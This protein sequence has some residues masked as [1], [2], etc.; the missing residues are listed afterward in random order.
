MTDYAS[1]GKTR[2]DNIV[3]LTHCKSHQS[4]YTAL[5][6][7]ASAAGTVILQSFSPSPIIGGA[8]GWLRQE[9]RELELLDEITKLTYE[10]KLPSHIIG[11]QRNT[12]ICDYREWRG[13][14]YVPRNMHS[15]IQWS[16]YK[17]YPINHTI[18]DSPWQIIDKKDTDNKDAPAMIA[19]NTQAAEGS[20][21][22][23]NNKKR[24]LDETSDKNVGTVKKLKLSVQ[25]TPVMLQS[26]IGPRWDSKNYSCAYDAVFSILCYI[27]S[28]NPHKWNK[29]F[30]GL[31]PEMALL[32]NGFQKLLSGNITLEDARDRVRTQLHQLDNQKFKWGT[33]GTAASDL[34]YMMFKKN[35]GAEIWSHCNTCQLR[36]QGFGDD[37]MYVIDSPTDLQ[38]S[39]TSQ[40]LQAVMN[41]KQHPTCNQCNRSTDYGL[42]TPRLIVF[43]IPKHK[44]ILDKKIRLKGM[45]ECNTVLHLRGIVYHGNFHFVSR[46]VTNDK[47]IWFHDGI[48]TGSN[49]VA[50]ANITNISDDYLTHCKGK[51]IALAIYAQK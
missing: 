26:P 38:H 37:Y 34:A 45:N 39:S 49:A 46:I 17:P 50:E 20:I 14:T 42:Q 28:T 11:H 7:S 3:D 2:P 5:S 23:T 25:N 35:N 12:L 1:Q 13:S 47:K 44:G 43:H 8:S 16:K 27:W 30:R 40:V 33:H 32:A 18:P 29:I 41:Q 36:T 15:A 19:T 10:S 51:I 6:R 9:F 24:K 31:N 48:L 22:I 21:P 4:Y